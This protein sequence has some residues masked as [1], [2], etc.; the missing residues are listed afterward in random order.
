MT[1]ARIAIVGLIGLVSVV[2]C[3]T[4]SPA[5]SPGLITSHAGSDMPAATTTEPEASAS[6]DPLAVCEAVEPE[7]EPIE[8]AVGT[9]SY[10]F[11]PQVIEGPRH[12]EPFVV[13]FTNSDVPVPGSRY[14][15]EH[16]IAIRAENLLGPVLFEGDVIGRETIR[17]EIPG[18]PAG[19]HYMYCTVH[20]EMSGSV[21]VAPA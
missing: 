13:V 7:G 3:S 10:D 8:M 18:L 16:N 5:A 17:Y 9:V 1:T 19:E 21:V 2:G 11:D 4:A 12:C 6:D 15:N 20:P 14:G